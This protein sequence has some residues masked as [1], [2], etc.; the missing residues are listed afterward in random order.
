MHDR[1]PRMMSRRRLLLGAGIGAGA[2]LTGCTSNT[3]ALVSGFAPSPMTA[4]GGVDPQYVSMYGPMED[5]GHLIP[6]INLRRVNPIYYRQEVAD[7]TGERPGTVVVDT[8]AKFAFVVMPGGRAMRYGVGVGREGFGWSGRAN[9]QWKRRWPTWTPPREMIERK[10]DLEPYANGMEGGIMNPLGAR[11][12]YLFQ[13]GRDTLYRLHGSPEY[14]TIGTA[15]S[16][17]CVRFMNQDIVDLYDR[18]PTGS[19]VIV[20]QGVVA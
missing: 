14:W 5:D 6:A 7:P 11:A 2:L 1:D 8:A 19:P 13:N 3:R 20:T 15:D 18:V 17:G 12:L 16:S 4:F 10:P 9:V